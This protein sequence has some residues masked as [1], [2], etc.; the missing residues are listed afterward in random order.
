M[1]KN[2]IKRKKFC[3]GYL[4]YGEEKEAKK[5]INETAKRLFCETFDL[6]GVCESCAEDIPRLA[7]FQRFS[8]PV[9]GI[10]E[11]RALI[12]ICSKKSFSG[13]KVFHIEFAKITLEAQNALLKILEEPPTGT[14]F[15]IYC[16]NL[17]NIIETLK[18]R[19]AVVFVPFSSDTE[20]KN[21]NEDIVNFLKMELNEKIDFFSSIKDR[22]EAKD[23]LLCLV[24]NFSGA[25]IS[26][27]RFYEIKKILEGIKMING[28]TPLSLA[29]LYCFGK[30]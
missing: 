14:Y 18:S 8:F 11:S 4:F 3:H 24:K 23:F 12:D 20:N 30:Q 19:L 13:R 1:L 7:D 15:L 28:N 26:E 29:G 10:D 16:K 6:C 27:N 25:D 9:F 2:H 21:K 5:I 17:E 22:E